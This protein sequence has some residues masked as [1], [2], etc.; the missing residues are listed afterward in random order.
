[1]FTS[2]WPSTV[3]SSLPRP[4]L[5]VRTRG[6][7]PW[8]Q[9]HLHQRTS[10]VRAGIGQ[11][12]A[13]SSGRRRLVQFWWLISRA[14]EG[15]PLRLE[16]GPWSVRPRWLR[17]SPTLFQLSRRLS[18]G[19]A[20]TLARIFWTGCLVTGVRCEPNQTACA[21]LARCPRCT[22]SLPRPLPARWASDHRRTIYRR[23]I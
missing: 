22:E 17:P 11:S 2:S 13:S 21:A 20:A 8:V 1:M 3:I 23:G 12:F 7:S 4:A 5:V 19:S 14:S 15:Q 10:N 6:G 16:P 18:G 9:A